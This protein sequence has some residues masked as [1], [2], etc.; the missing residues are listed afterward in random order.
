MTPCEGK[1]VHSVGLFRTGLKSCLNEKNTKKYVMY[2]LIYD[3]KIRYFKKTAI[4][5]YQFNNIEYLNVYI[6]E[7]DLLGSLIITTVN[8]LVSRK[9]T[10][11]FYHNCM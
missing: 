11:S 8:K 2:M 10:S 5:R 7:T 3:I 1:S 9:T 6:F 4:I